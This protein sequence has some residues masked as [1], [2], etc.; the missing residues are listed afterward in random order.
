MIE[1]DK[2]QLKGINVLSHK[3]DKHTIVVDER[4]EYGED[5][6]VVWDER[7]ANHISTN[8][9]V[10]HHFQRRAHDLLVS[11]VQRIYKA[12]IKIHSRM[13]DLD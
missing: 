8:H 10:L 4:V 9:Q 2:S 5:L 3:N 11:S 1:D 13:I 6:A 12:D 7:L